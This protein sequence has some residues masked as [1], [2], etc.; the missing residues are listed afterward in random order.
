[1][2]KIKKDLSCVLHDPDTNKD[3]LSFTAQQVGD[4]LYS[5]SFVGGGVAS[6]SQN[7]TI[8]TET[9]Y[10]YKPLQHQ[11]FVDGQ[12][13][14]LSSFYPSIRRKLGGGTAHKPRKVYVLNLE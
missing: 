5:A 12:K 9:E 10:D 7:L 1:M 13:W 3:L 4:P 2:L 11:V 14:I 6:S 8:E